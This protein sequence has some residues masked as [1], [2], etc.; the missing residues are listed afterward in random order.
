[1]KTCSF[2]IHCDERF[3]VE[4]L[5]EPAVDI[6]LQGGEVEG[7]VFGRDKGLDALVPGIR[8]I[9]R[10]ACGNCH[11]DRLVELTGV[12]AGCAEFSDVIPILVENDNALVACVCDEHIPFRVH[13]HA[14]RTPERARR[15]SNARQRLTILSPHLDRLAILSEFLNAVVPRVA[16]VD[17]AV[18]SNGDAPRFVERADRSIA[19]ERVRERTPLMKKASIGRDVQDA[20]V[21]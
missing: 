6:P 11:T 2:A 20:M 17:R 9:D 5:S 15:F 16:H 8:H 21:A 10:S 14:A 12:E 4:R 7:A 13:R 18:G 1:M 3:I 19:C